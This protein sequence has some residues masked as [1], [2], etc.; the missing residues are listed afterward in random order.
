MHSP[1]KVAERL[2]E[3]NSNPPTKWRGITILLLVA[4]TSI[5]WTEVSLTVRR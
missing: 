1:T 5:P 2:P 4:V 3:P